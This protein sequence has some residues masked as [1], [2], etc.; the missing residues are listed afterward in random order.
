[1]EQKGNTQL[2]IVRHGETEWNVKGVWQGQLN[3]PLTERGE[4]QAEAVAV[5]LKDYPIAHIYSSDLG[6]CIQSAS[7]TAR[8]LELELKTDIRLRERGFGVLEGMSKEESQE[9]YPGVWSGL[10]RKDIDFAPEGGESLRQKQ[11]RFEEVYLEIA[12][13]HVGETVVVF[14]HGGGVDAILRTSLGIGIE[15]E[16]PYTLW[17]SALNI[18]SYLNGHW[19]VDTLGDI[20]HLKGMESAFRPR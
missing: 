6:R 17:N 15:A 7:P 1:M 11:V 18:V 13:R 5:R 10:S 16:R 2:I 8:I 4:K 20:A 3:S 14:T 12:E 19:T 9:R